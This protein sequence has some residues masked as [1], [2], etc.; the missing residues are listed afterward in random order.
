MKSIYTLTLPFGAIQFTT[1]PSVVNDI[2]ALP[3]YAMTLKYKR[4]EN[5]GE[6]PAAAEFPFGLK[7]DHLDEKVLKTNN[8][9]AGIFKINESAFDLI[10]EAIRYALSQKDIRNM[11]RNEVDPDTSVAGMEYVL[12]P[13]SASQKTAFMTAAYVALTDR[14]S[15]IMVDYGPAVNPVEKVVID[16]GNGVKLLSRPTYL[17]AP[18]A[19]ERQIRGTIEISGKL[20]NFTVGRTRA[21]PFKK[22]VTC[23]VVQDAYSYAYDELQ[24]LA[25][26]RALNLS[27]VLSFVDDNEELPFAEPSQ[28]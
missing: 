15:Q 25:S 23:D 8:I 17:P 27:P 16:L 28:E 26:F 9:K 24:K 3:H 2:H 10:E 19:N 6:G 1:L 11:I 12:E 22:H 13:F 7:L 21:M 14:V 4:R 18:E 5:G 20:Q